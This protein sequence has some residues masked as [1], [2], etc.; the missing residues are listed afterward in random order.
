MVA[1][2][3]VGSVAVP[4]VSAEPALVRVAVAARRAWVVSAA[5]VG[6]AAA[7]VAAWAVVAAAD[8]A[9]AAAADAVA[10]VAEGGN[11]Q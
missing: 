5:V 8:A 1:D 9:V 6:A 7:V 11:E 10:A 3:A 2:E 4:E